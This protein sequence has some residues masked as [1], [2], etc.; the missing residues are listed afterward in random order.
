[1]F[2]TALLTNISPNNGFCGVLPFALNCRAG[3]AQN[4]PSPCTCG[5]G[6]TN[7]QIV[8]TALGTCGTNTA[9]FALLDGTCQDLAIPA[10]GVTLTCTDGY[11]VVSGFASGATL[12]GL[13][14]LACSCDEIV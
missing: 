7:G 3:N 1:M 13:S 12:E 14:S 11:I 2:D 10:G 9:G 4:Y 6:F 8:A 5:V